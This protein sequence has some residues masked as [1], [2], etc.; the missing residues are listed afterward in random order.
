MFMVRP[1]GHR[2]LAAQPGGEQF[3]GADEAVAARGQDDGPQ[4][5]DDFVGAIRRGGDGGVEADEGVADER[6]DEDLVRAAGQVGRGD[7]LPAH[8]RPASPRRDVGGDALG[9]GRAQPGRLLAAE[10]VADVEFDGGLFGEHWAIGTL[11]KLTL[12]KR[13]GSVSSLLLLAVSLPSQF[14]T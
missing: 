12:M 4:A 8:A 9:H 6:P 7:K 11:V 3:V 2:H 5:V 10:E 13:S 1:E 14:G